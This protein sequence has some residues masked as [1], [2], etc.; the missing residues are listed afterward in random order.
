MKRQKLSNQGFRPLSP[1]VYKTHEETV[2]VNRRDQKMQYKAQQQLQM[3]E[4][5]AFRCIS[6]GEEL[7]EDVNEL[8]QARKRMEKQYI[9]NLQEGRHLRKNTDQ[10][11]VLLEYFQQKQVWD[12]PMKIAIAEELNMTLSQVSKWNWDHRK[13][14]GISTERI[15]PKKSR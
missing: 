1:K 10:I 8:M 6:G 3:E 7:E 12:Y 5:R 11:K 14:L 2:Y 9:Q 4:E 13:K 15:R